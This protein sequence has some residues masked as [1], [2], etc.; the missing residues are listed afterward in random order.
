MKAKLLFIA[1]SFF[2]LSVFAQRGKNLNY[3]ATGNVV[4]NA[5]T[6]LTANATVNASTITVASNSLTSVALPVALGAGDLILII[7]MQGATM[8]INTTPATPVANGGWGGNYT[9]SNGAMADFGNL[10]NYRDEWGQVTAYNNSGKYEYAQVSSISGGT[11]IN[12]Q[13]GL[14]NSYDVSGRTQIVRVPRFQNLTLDPNASIVPAAWNGNT[15]G[16]AALEI[17][18]N[19]MFGNNSR[20]SATAL[21]FRGGALDPTGFGP[22]GNATDVGKPGYSAAGEGAEKGEGIGGHAT[23]EYTTLYSRYG[24]GSPANGGGGGNYRNAGG[25]G[26]SNVGSG[27]YTGYGVPDPAF[28]AFWNLELPGMSASPSSGGGRGGYS[29]AQSNQNEAT[30]GP[31]QSAWSGDYRRTEGGFGGHPLIYD[32]S[33][34][35]MGGG[36]GAGEQ[37]GTQG[38]AG[39]KGGG[40]VFIQ[41]FGSMSGVGTIEARG[42]RGQNSNPNNQN[43]AITNLS[44]QLRGNDGAGGGGAGGSVL[45]SNTNPIPASITINVSGGRGGH[46]TLAFFF[47]SPTNIPEC[48]GPGGG[49]SGGFVNFSSGTPTLVL[50]GGANGIVKTATNPV[51]IVANFPPNGATSGASGVSMTTSTFFDIQVNN[52]TICSGQTATLTATI[53]GTQPPGSTI[54][55]YTTQFGNTVAGTGLN[56][57]TPALTATTTYYVGVCPG[58][59]RIRVTVTV[60]GPTISGTATINNATCTTGGSITGLITSGGAAPITISWNG[61]TTPSMS[62]NN[63]SPGTYNVLVTDNAGCT[64]TAGP[65]VIGTTGGP[66]LN[67]TN[68]TVIDANCLGNNGSIS[69]IT[70]TG[71]GLTYN[72]N[73]GAYNTL[74]ISGLAAGTYS[75]VVTD[76]L[77]CTAN[78]GPITVGQIPGPTIDASN[79]T[80]IGATCG[81]ANGS[82]TGITAS[83][84]GLNVTWNGQGSSLNVSNLAAGSYNVVVT[85]NLGCTAN[86]GPV[87][88]TGSAG[89]TLLTS[90]IVIANAHCGNAIGSISGIGISGGTNPMV[91]S[92][93]SGAY[94][95]LDIT[96]VPAGSYSLT[97]TDF[98]GCIANAGPYTISDVPGPTIDAS[99]IQIQNESCAGNDGSITGLSTTGTVMV[100]NWNGNNTTGTDLIGVSAGTY[101][102]SVVDNFGCSANA[103]PFVVSGA[104][105]M[106]I[107]SSNLVVT[108]SGCSLPTGAINGLQVVGG[109]NPVVS[110][111]NGPLTLNNQ[112]ILAGTY[113]I[114]VVDDQGCNISASFTVPTISGLTVN[115]TNAVT[116]PEY[117][118]QGNGTVTGVTV[119]GGTSPY[120]YQWDGNNNLTTL[121]ISIFDAGVHTVVVTDAGGCTASGTITIGSE[122]GPTVDTTLMQVVD[123]SCG[124]NNGSITGIQVSGNGPFTYAWTNTAQTTLNVTNLGAGSYNLLVVDANQCTSDGITIDVQNAGLINADYS[125]SGGTIIPGTVVSFIDESVGDVVTNWQWVIDTNGVVGTNS[126]LQFTFENEGVFPVTLIVTSAAGCVDSIT[127]LITV[128]GELIIPNIVTNNGD[129]VNDIFEV[130]NLKPNSTL[131]IQNRW[132]NVVFSTENYLNNWKGTDQ[133][134]DELIEGVYFYQLF[135]VDDKVWSGFIHLI[136]M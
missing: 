83:G 105:P 36:G 104:V 118:Q 22:A 72:W 54:T 5:Y 135:N 8:D 12:L 37:D 116:T 59:F 76:N 41:H 6:T 75:L 78:A 98:N 57:T 24:N 73:G 23:T 17:N 101:S 127:K 64:A 86:Y 51:N 90:G 92:W 99:N 2:T 134:G 10:N 58:T 91:I 89:P 65:F 14:R 108:P 48:Q 56:F 19:L 63:A 126:N 25:G 113:T 100:F 79:I 97:V 111:S 26:G 15:G 128:Y 32:P 16:V 66:T 136:N 60:G 80:V 35:F 40:I 33:R 55:W 85:D 96:N 20:I 11:I 30:L 46:D 114:T 18:G 67:T 106:T 125:F 21:G 27:T 133:S 94:T 115:T 81:L 110:W 130:K 71:T 38:G 119:S 70:A 117:C 45:I 103:G 39:G 3:T 47:S 88:V 43:P 9:V 62:L 29:F 129:G 13:C 69:G 122:V 123:A 120:T 34:V 31:N 53:L 124:Q 49:G 93:N 50:T 84:N 74:N 132:G 4:V 7:Q 121:D 107:D 112:N 95:T 42:E 109:I 68:L 28:A 61:I 131:I 77:G 82:I 1:L 52:V 102:L 44:T 87:T